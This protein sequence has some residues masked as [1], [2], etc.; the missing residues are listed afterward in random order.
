[1]G[2]IGASI[3]FSLFGWTVLVVV[4][5]V[6]TVVL[7]CLLG[8]LSVLRRRDARWWWRWGA[9]MSIAW[10]GVLTTIGVLVTQYSTLRAQFLTP[11]PPPT[12]VQHW[13]LY[14]VALVALVAMLIGAGRQELR[15]RAI[16]PAVA[17]AGV[18][19]TYWLRAITPDGQTWTYYG[20]KTLWAI[21]TT[22]L[23]V[24]FLPLADYALGAASATG[25]AWR[26]RFAPVGAAAGGVAGL[27]VI[28]FL[29]NVANPLRAAANGWTQPSAAVMA[30]V[31]AA[32]NQ[33]SPF[34]LWQWS[35]FGDERLG[36]FW[37]VL[38]WGST[39]DGQVTAAFPPSLPGGLYG[40][41]YAENGDFRQLC[42]LARGVPG[43]HVITATPSLV[44]QMRDSCPASGA[45]VLV[46]PR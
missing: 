32:G 18:A 30:E 34:V 10:G 44:K 37:A 2:L 24:V 33:R 11:G 41:G 27:I 8:R 12:P 23:W 31:T 42:V 20:A 9:G 26:R 40:W 25:P 6:A 1:L 22:V 15:A 38:T 35:D 28:G 21:A 17:V 45:H 39:P 4:P 16:A 13:T 3:V 14:L 19:T 29:S 5:V 36:D 43:L 7:T 46:V